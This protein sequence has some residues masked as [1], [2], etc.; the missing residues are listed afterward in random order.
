M[1]IKTFL[2]CVVSFIAVFV[3]SYS[4]SIQICLASSSETKGTGAQALAKIFYMKGDVYHLRGKE[5]SKAK[6]NL[7]LIENDQI[8][9]TQNAV[10]ILSFGKDFTS[11]M[12]LDRGTTVVIEKSKF[13]NSGASNSSPAMLSSVILKAGNILV[14]YDKDKSSAAKDDKGKEK[15]NDYKFEVKTKS[16]AM[17][18]RGTTF[19]AYV[20]K[21]NPN[22]TSMSVKEGVVD[23][24]N[25]DSEKDKVSVKESMS[26][27]ALDS[28]DAKNIMEPS[29]QT[30]QEK[31]NWELSP[32][33]GKDLMQPSA[34]FDEIEKKYKEWQED[35]KKKKEAWNKDIDE[36][37]K[38]VF[39]R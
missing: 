11:K 12:K 31:I 4:L 9:T 37:K 39:G 27:F 15:D 23:V 13:G 1:K 21:D 6:E 3:C 24:R 29:K 16:A 32:E 30:W 17:G 33:G 28:K 2:C 5:I 7:E 36:Q 35:I 20:N 18:V 25:G 14:N 34:L 10:L 19:F 22:Q 26:T 38:R 8:K